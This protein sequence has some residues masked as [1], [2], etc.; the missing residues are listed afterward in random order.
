MTCCSANAASRALQSSS[1]NPINAR[2][3]L[4][5]AVAALP[6]WLTAASSFSVPLSATHRGGGARE[7]PVTH[8]CY[9]RRQKLRCSNDAALDQHR[10]DTYLHI[11]HIV[12]A[13]LQTAKTEPEF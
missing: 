7:Q 1:W 13:L 11:A 2:V 9:F 10:E 12:K 6:S 3:V 4:R 8:V 5:A